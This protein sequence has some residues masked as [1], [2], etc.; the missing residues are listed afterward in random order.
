[1]ESIT[2]LGLNDLLAAKFR[3]EEKKLLDAR[4]RLAASVA[5]KDLP[6]VRVVSTA[7][8]LKAMDAVDRLVARKPAEAKEALASI[9]ESI[10]LTPGVDGYTAKL[11]L[12]TEQAAPGGGL[13][14]QSGCGGGIWSKTDLL[15]FSADVT[16]IRGTSAS[17]RLVE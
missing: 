5:P 15:P 4:Q 10:V 16:P 9:V 2:S 3:D 1:M 14:V 12:K 11:T 8:V 7:Q 17:E 6:P 13:F